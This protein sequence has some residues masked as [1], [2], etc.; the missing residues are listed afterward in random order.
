MAST[1]FRVVLFDDLGPDS[2]ME[3]WLD[4]GPD[5]E[6]WK[7]VDELLAHSDFAYAQMYSEHDSIFY[8]VER[9]GPDAC[10][11]WFG[12]FPASSAAHAALAVRLD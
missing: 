7:L 1:F 3:V 4:Q 9:I 12:D 11:G 2:S 8:S 10:R 6:P 5:G